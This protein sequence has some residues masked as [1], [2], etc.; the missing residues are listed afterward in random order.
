MVKFIPI[1]GTTSQINN[2]PIVNGQVLFET[3]NSDGQNHIYVDTDSE[4]VPMG[5]SEWSQVRNK[6]FETIGSGLTVVNDVLTADDVTWSQ[7]RN[8]PFE[9]IGSGLTVV[10]GVL[11]ANVNVRNWDDVSNKPFE[12]IGDGLT[13]DGNNRLNANVRIV[14]LTTEGSTGTGNVSEYQRLWVNTS[15][16]S[17]FSEIMGTRHMQYSQTLSTTENTVYEFST[18]S[19]TDNSA[20]DVF[21]SIWGFDP[22][23]V[24]VSSGT[25]RVTFPPY[26]TS[27]TTMICRIYIK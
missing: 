7:V 6:P 15:G 26:D 18:G 16:T 22:I 9:T 20:I 19:I 10:N 11:N 8:K 3:S 2:T 1:R 23:N 25:C 21:T 5:I 12:T 14:R 24:S 27:N 4:R 17:A 13:V